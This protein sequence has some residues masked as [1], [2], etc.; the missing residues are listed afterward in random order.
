MGTA[1]S[2]ASGDVLV[3]A[4]VP[5]HHSR[6]KGKILGLSEKLSIPVPVLGWSREKRNPWD[7]KRKRKRESERLRLGFFG[8]CNHLKGMGKWSQPSLCF[9][10]ISFFGIAQVG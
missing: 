9:I 2:S 7:R 1:G 10:S 3:G 6:R 5:F 4:R 8:D